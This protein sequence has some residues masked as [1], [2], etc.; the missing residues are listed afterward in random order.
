MPTLHF[1]RL[2]RRRVETAPIHLPADLTTLR[3]LI[4]ACVRH[5]VVRYNDRQVGGDALPYLLPADIDA[6]GQMGKVGFGQVAEPRAADE[7]KAIADALQAYEDGL[8]AVFVDEEEVRGLGSPLSL[9]P[10][11]VV[12]LVRLVALAGR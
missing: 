2:G 12:A 4:V 11:S 3:D 5:E 6:Q 7:A 1:K 8:Y 10:E 9:K